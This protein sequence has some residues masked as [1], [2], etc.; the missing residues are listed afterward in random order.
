MI[1]VTRS[2]MRNDEHE[3]DIYVLRWSIG[4]RANGVETFSHVM[5]EERHRYELQNREGGGKKTAQLANA[6]EQQR[7]LIALA[8]CLFQR[9]NPGER[10]LNTSECYAALHLEIVGQCGGGG[11]RGGGGET[12]LSHTR[13]TKAHGKRAEY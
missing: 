5:P 6:E 8:N 4:M 12:M 13:T 2:S 1:F 9:L 10:F 3:N 11:G 7:N